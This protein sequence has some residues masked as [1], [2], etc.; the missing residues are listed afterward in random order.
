MFFNPFHGRVLRKSLFAKSNL[1]PR[2]WEQ[3]VLVIFSGSSQFMS[4]EERFKS[5]PEVVVKV[6]LLQPETSPP[7][8]SLWEGQPWGLSKGGDTSVESVKL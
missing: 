4:R 6:H 3:L 7:E 5:T 1:M 2:I 8:L